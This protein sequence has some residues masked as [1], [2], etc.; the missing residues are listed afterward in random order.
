MIHE[1]SCH[2]GKIAFEV[3]GDIKQVND[4]NCSH[5]SRKGYL[6]W[7]TPRSQ[8]RLKTPESD[9]STYTFNRHA[10]NHHFCSTCG[11]A[12]FGFGK[13]RDGNELA[14]VNVRCLPDLD[15]SELEIKQVD[16]RSL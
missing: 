13:D 10:I 1:G 4:C 11:C 5:C 14:A 7:F 16:G 2:C 9:L 8:L 3:E 15:R 12:P 6:I